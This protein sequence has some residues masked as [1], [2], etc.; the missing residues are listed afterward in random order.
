MLDAKIRATSN[1]LCSF[2]LFTIVYQDSSGYTKSVYD[3]LQKLDRYLMG[4][5][6]HW[7]GSHPLGERI[8]FDE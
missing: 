8:N 1:E 5:V 4:Y 6:H 7:H 2:E 3:A